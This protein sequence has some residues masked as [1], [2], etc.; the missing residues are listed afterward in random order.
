MPIPH[1]INKVIVFNTTHVSQQDYELLSTL[2][3][4]HSYDEGVFIHVPTDIDYS[5]RVNDVNERGFSPE[6]LQLMEEAYKADCC[7]LQLDCDGPDYDHLPTFE[8]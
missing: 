4:C 5:V 1:E 7:W 3:S 6:F 8:W 2:P